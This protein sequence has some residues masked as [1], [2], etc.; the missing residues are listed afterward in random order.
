VHPDDR[1]SDAFW[2]NPVQ[3]YERANS[4]LLQLRIAREAGFSIPDT[5]MSNDPAQI[6]RFVAER[7]SDGVV[8][9]TFFPTRWELADGGRAFLPTTEISLDALPE[10]D[11]LRLTPGIFQAKL[12]KAY[13]IRVTVMGRECVPARIDWRAGAKGRDDWRFDLGQDV[14]VKDM[15]LP[16]EVREPCLKVMSRLGIVFGCFD[17]I[18]TPDGETV[19]LE[20]NEMG[21]FLWVETALPQHSLLDMFCRF[22]I[23]GRPDFRYE[24]ET[25]RLEFHSLQETPEFKAALERS[26]ALHVN[27]RRP[28]TAPSA[29]ADKARETRPQ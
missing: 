20:V 1:E 12:P 23:E 5:L 17:L 28:R 22:L 3:S 13:E 8:Y 9:K 4:K 24:P 2:V 6:R 11:I 15:P 10:D 18:V 27:R 29:A 21:Q 14:T 25:P 7:E 16:E 26:E 19:F